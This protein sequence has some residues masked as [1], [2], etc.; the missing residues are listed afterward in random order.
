MCCAFELRRQL[1]PNDLIDG[2]DQ[3][4]KS[5]CLTIFLDATTVRQPLRDNGKRHCHAV[6]VRKREERLSWSA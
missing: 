2:I 4:T 5:I 6:E 3:T 1:A